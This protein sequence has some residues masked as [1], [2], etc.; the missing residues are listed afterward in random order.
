[1]GV[2]LGDAAANSI[3]AVSKASRVRALG[4]STTASAAF[5]MYVLYHE[6]RTI[7]QA[8]E[9]RSEKQRSYRWLAPSAGRLARDQPLLFPRSRTD[10]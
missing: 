6:L 2:R 9:S 3:A 8:L 5:C 7:S 4:F 10:E 1:M